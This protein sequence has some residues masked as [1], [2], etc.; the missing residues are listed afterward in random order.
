MEIKLIEST[1]TSNLNEDIIRDSFN[2]RENWSLK[3]S[4]NKKSSIKKNL[5]DIKKDNIHIGV[6]LCWQLED[7]L[8]IEYFA[9]E[10]KHRCLGYGS[11]ALKELLKIH[12]NIIVEVVPENINSLACRRINWYKS[13]GFHLHDNIYPYP[14]FLDD[15][16]V[17][18]IEFRIMSSNKLNDYEYKKAVNLI[19]KNIYN[20]D[21]FYKIK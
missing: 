1:N 21:D 11:A 13:L 3:E 17:T 8:Y 6:C 15:G 19:H 12:N 14:Y 9:I 16:K 18:F 2:I 5:Y 20:I 10:R 4:F 7:F